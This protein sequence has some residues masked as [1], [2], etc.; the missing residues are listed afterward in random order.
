MTD[1]RS[2]SA[3]LLDELYLI[4][5]S[6]LP[7]EHLVISPS[8]DDKDEWDRLLETYP[9]GS[10]AAE[11]PAVPPILQLRVDGSDVWFEISIPRDYDSADKGTSV[12]PVSVK[13]DQ[14]TRTAQ[15]RWQGSVTHLMQKLED[16]ECVRVV[17]AN[18]VSTF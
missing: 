16:S 14:L 15:E 5:C 4:K 7:G 18:P 17:Y 2:P 8:C 3:K 6:L 9:E 1:A 12:P 11:L 13:G 10:E